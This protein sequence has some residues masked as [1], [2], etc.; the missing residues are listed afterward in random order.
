[1]SGKFAEEPSR[2]IPFDL[3]S[4]AVYVNRQWLRR[5]GTVRVS[6]VRGPSQPLQPTIGRAT[7]RIRFLYANDQTRSCARCQEDG[8]EHVH[9]LARARRFHGM[10]YPRPALKPAPKPAPNH[11][12]SEVNFA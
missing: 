6:A 2:Q 8:N 9:L 12:L 10:S 1:M 3:N 5:R 7:R 11:P 4:D